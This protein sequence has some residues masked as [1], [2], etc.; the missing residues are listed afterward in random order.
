MRGVQTFVD[1][2]DSDAVDEPSGFGVA[3]VSLP[4]PLA[5]I[6]FGVEVGYQRLEDDGPLGG[7]EQELTQDIFWAG[8]RAELLSGHWRPHIGA[9]VLFVDGE[10]ERSF[11]NVS[12]SDDLSSP[13]LYVELGS[14][15]R[16]SNVLHLGFG[17]RQT[18]LLEDDV[19]GQEVEFDFTEI[20]ASVGLSF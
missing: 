18:F 19:D 7:I 5:Y 11:D 9:G 10:V 20:Y 12:N 6:P 16:L 2:G 13:G 17:A 4:G 1:D 14:R 8:V 15:V 3:L